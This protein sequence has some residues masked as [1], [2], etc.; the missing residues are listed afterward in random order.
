MPALC[1]VCCGC[2]RFMGKDGKPIDIATPDGFVVWDERQFPISA[3]LDPVTFDTK[4]SADEFCLKYG[5]EVKDSY[6]P[7][8][9]CPDCINAQRERLK[10]RREAEEVHR[11][12]Y[13]DM[14]LLQRANAGKPLTDTE[15]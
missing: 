5:W 14:D 7:N 9:R 11:G 3:S 12:A 4:D 15:R 1:V 13:I 6:G 10:A 8:H 2:Q